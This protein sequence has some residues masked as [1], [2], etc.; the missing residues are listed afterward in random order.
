[1][2]DEDFR[3]DSVDGGEVGPGHS[4]TALYAVRLA[5]DADRGAEVARVRVRWL[6]PASRNAAEEARPVTVADVDGEFAAA[7]PRFTVDYVAAQLAEAL[8]GGEAAIPLAEL[9]RIADRAAD[10]TEDPAVRELADLVRR[11]G[12]LR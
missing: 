11:A 1:V 2:A 10:R 9:S 8:R 6:D 5:E 3:D 12:E 4:V 7:A